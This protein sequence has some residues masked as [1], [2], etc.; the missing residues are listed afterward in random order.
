MNGLPKYVVS[1]T[2]TDP[3]WNNSAVLEGD[4]VDAVWK[5]KRNLDGEIRVYAS[6]Q[7]VQTLIEHDLV[8]ELRLMIFPLVVGAGNRL[9]DQ[10]SS[11][12]PAR[13]KPLRLVDTRTVGDGLSY[14]T[15]RC[16]PN[17]NDS[18]R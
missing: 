6:S 14:L 4:V 7:L 5:L 18:S 9:F 10:T 16:V 1:T 11:P 3:C 15:Y 12:K 13:P 8:D 17:A 2:L